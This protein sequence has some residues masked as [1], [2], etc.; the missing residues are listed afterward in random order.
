MGIFIR[1]IADDPLAQVAIATVLLLIA[2]DVVVGFTGAAITKT[3]SST[4][5]RA[6]LLHKLMELAAIALA[7]IVDGALLGG[8][9]IVDGSPI[10]V[11][12][13]A[14]LAVMEAASVLELIAKYNPDIAGAGVFTFVTKKDAEDD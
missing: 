5:M 2:L 13:C 12:V 11:A 10:L 7:T 1:P 6:G 4:K 3:I 14:Y 8:F 9:D